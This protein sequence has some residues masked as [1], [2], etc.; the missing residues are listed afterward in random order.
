MTELEADGFPRPA[1]HKYSV[2]DISPRPDY[3]LDL[4]KPSNLNGSELGSVIVR[5][6]GTTDAPE[7]GSPIDDPIF[8]QIG[9]STPD[10]FGRDVDISAMCRQAESDCTNS[11]KSRKRSART[12]SLPDSIPPD[13]DYDGNRHKIMMTE[14][15]S[16]GRPLLESLYVVDTSALPV[17]Q[18]IDLQKDV[19][20]QKSQPSRTSSLTV[21]PIEDP[22]SAR[23][24]PTTQV[25]NDTIDSLPDYETPVFSPE[26]SPSKNERDNIDDP[27][28]DTVDSNR[29][30]KENLASRDDRSE[31]LRV[32]NGS[33]ID[34]GGTD[35]PEDDLPL[36][37]GTPGSS[38]NFPAVTLSQVLPQEQNDKE[39]ELALENGIVYLKTPLRISPMVYKIV[40]TFEVVLRKG[41]STDWWE[42]DLRG[43]PTLAHSELGYIYFRSNPGQGIE[44]ATSPFKRSTVV[45]NCLMALFTPGM[46][47]VV[48]LRQCS[49]EHYGFISDY[50][51]NSILHSE[52][53]PQ[54]SGYEIEYT[55]VCSV[56]LIN[57]RFLSE[58]CSFHMYVHGAPE[59]RYIGDFTEK[60]SSKSSSKNH[61]KSADSPLIHNLFLEPTED[62]KI[63]V[64]HIEM[65]C[66]LA[67]LNMFAVQWS[68]KVQEGKALV[69]PRIKSTS[70]NEPDEKLRRSFDLVDRNQ[71]TLA[72]PWVGCAAQSSCDTAPLDE[73]LSLVQHKEMFPQ[74]DGQKSEKQPRLRGLGYALWTLT[75]RLFD[76]CSFLASVYFIWWSFIRTSHENTELD[77]CRCCELMNSYYL[78]NA[79]ANATDYTTNIVYTNLTSE[80]ASL[81]EIEEPGL[82]HTETLHVATA[83]NATS[84]LRDRIDYFLGW[85]GPVA[86]D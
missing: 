15:D 4:S 77:L 85:R 45:E 10:D 80:W 66:P 62:A 35:E 78:S 20:T 49:A 21:N 2:P 17:S 31:S 86:R 71:Y 9:R 19:P 13:E 40:I 22:G 53:F 38:R 32:W 14:T 18:P 48:P 33:L 51:I 16:E 6:T 5:D 52:I 26:T 7:G 64:S 72:R 82:M 59:G 55:A 69:I 11:A 8:R 34:T 42:L 28:T 81:V 75:K 65:T 60:Q 68:V 63:G 74:N 50:K 36:S 67:A 37:F 83:E 58:Q 47:L 57:H 12:A 84:S 76:I 41:K 29:L 56:D 54:T 79:G 61:S 25:E 23:Y 44:F 46:N 24:S 73:P 1:G 3:S 70:G 30:T 27:E 43:L 39:P